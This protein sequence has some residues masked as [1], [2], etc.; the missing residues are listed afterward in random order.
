LGDGGG[1][2]EEGGQV[3]REG[4]EGRRGREWGGRD[5]GDFKM[6]WREEAMGRNRGE[7]DKLVCSAD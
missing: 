3:G 5:G 4:R 6:V 7:P 2:D 1:G